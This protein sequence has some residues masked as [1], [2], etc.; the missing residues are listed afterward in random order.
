MLRKEATIVR[1]GLGGE[2]FFM[3]M[4][5]RVTITRPRMPSWFG[6]LSV[7]AILCAAAGRVGTSGKHTAKD[8]HCARG[9]LL[10]GQPRA[11]AARHCS[12][13]GVAPLRFQY[14]DPIPSSYAISCSIVPRFLNSAGVR[15]LFRAVGSRLLRKNGATQFVRLRDVDAAGRDSDC[16][17]GG[18]LAGCNIQRR[19]FLG[20]GDG[21]E[22]SALSKIHEERRVIGYSP[23]QLFN[24]V[25]A[26]DL[27]E[28]F[29]P[30]CQ[31]SQIVQY[32]PDGSFGAELE[33]G[34]KFLVES[35]VSHVVLN[36]PKSIK[37][38]STQSNLFDHLI[39]IW[40]FSPGPTPGTC[41]LYFIV[42]FKF[43]SPLYRQVATMFFKEVVTRL[44]SSFIDRCRLI[45]GPE[46]PVLENYN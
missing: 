36:K 19:W 46:T 25:A 16:L 1:F 11:A 34:F 37:T 14:P 39:N 10:Q 2:R 43:Q 44:V 20:C 32:Y 28:D 8:R 38:T 30:W 13:T 22:G 12:C 24:V 15:S 42:D 17:A 26:V 33:I 31:R 40:E 45:Y 9:I 5:D 35:Y 7:K 3:V 6:N 18:L 29:L 27:Y 41:S 23:E 4:D 21:A